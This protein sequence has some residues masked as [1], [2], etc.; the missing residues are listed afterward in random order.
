MDA[1][2]EKLLHLYLLLRDTGR[3]PWE[4]GFEVPRRQFRLA[5]L[6]LSQGCQAR[7]L[8]GCPL[9]GERT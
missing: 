3:F 2:G 9:V 8:A 7:A 4:F 1:L 6:I 5:A